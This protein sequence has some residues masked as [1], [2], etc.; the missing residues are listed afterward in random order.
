MA[1]FHMG[2]Q[3]TGYEKVA[4]GHP[5]H[6]T[7]YYTRMHCQGGEAENLN[8][9][10]DHLH[11]EV[12]K[13]WLDT[14]SILFCHTLEYQNK[15]SNLFMESEDANEALHDCIWTVIL[16]VMEDAGASTS[17]GLGIAVCLVD[18]LSTIL[19]HLTSHT[20][21]LSL[22]SFMP[23]VYAGWPWLRMNI[24]DLTHM[25]PLQSDQNALDVLSEEIINN[26]GD[27]SKVA[28]AAEPTACF[29]VA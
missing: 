11:Q 8:E 28:K 29:S 7:S 27:T 16:K 10:F 18:M 22:T 19:I 9:T 2:A 13:T 15:L 4:S 3:A 14:N 26:L 23:E 12:G 1:L 25:P 21:T 24:M 17:K 5:D 20:S 6:V